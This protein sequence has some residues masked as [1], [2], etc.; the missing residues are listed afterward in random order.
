MIDV[1]EQAFKSYGFNFEIYDLPLALIYPCYKERVMG[2]TRY[3]GEYVDSLRGLAAELGYDRSPVEDFGIEITSPDTDNRSGK[4][5]VA[6]VE[7]AQPL[8]GDVIDQH[9][10]VGF[11][12]IL[13]PKSNIMSSERRSLLMVFLRQVTNHLDVGHEVRLYEK[14]ASRLFNE[15]VKLF[16]E[17]GLFQNIIQV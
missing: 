3:P 10:E 11:G 1:L 13:I 9:V 7:G 16:K 15:F 6:P 5:L 4:I 2:V 12:L 8:E 14:G 17:E